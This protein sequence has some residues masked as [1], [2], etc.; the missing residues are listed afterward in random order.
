MDT[1]DAAAFTLIGQL[2]DTHVVDPGPD[3][4]VPD[5]VFVDNNARLRSAV[6]TL[7]RESPALDAVLG[8]GDLTNWGRPGEY[9]RLAELLAPL[10]SPFLPIPG[11]HD[12]RD[13][14]RATFPD[15]P[16]IDAAHASWVTEVGGVRIV[17]LDS[18]IPGEAGAEVDEPRQRWLTDVLAVP[19]DRVTIL[20]LHHP[21]FATGV[22]WMDASGF[23]GLDRLEA[24]LGE[25]PVDKVVCGHFHRPVSSTMAGIPVQVGLSTVQHVDLDLVP[26]AGPSLIV[27]PVGYQIHRIAG[28]RVVT[29]TRYIDTPERSSTARIIPTWADEF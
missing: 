17:G 6:A 27:D 25:H 12:D 5:E 20:A 19:Y 24:V 9:D 29:H 14:L 15:V 23:V 1:T 26:G 18:T 16:W 2:T 22:G 11:N 21:P 13:R 4:V 3:G 7:N 8:T 28:R 10:T